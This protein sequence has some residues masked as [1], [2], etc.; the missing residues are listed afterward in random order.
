MS[1]IDNNLLPDEKIIFRTK[2]HPIVFLVPGIFLLLAIFFSTDNVLTN[3][4]NHTFSLVTN[5]IPAIHSIHRLPGLLFTLAFIVSGTQQWILYQ[6]SD[7]VVTSNRVIMREGLFI[8]RTSDMRLSTIASVSTDQGLLAQMLNYG[9]ISLNGF[10]GLSED[11][12]QIAKP[13]EF[14]KYAHIQLGK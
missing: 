5:Q 9:N 10:G 14:Q 3:A 4:M 1:Y 6:M 2:K 12:M 7:Y 11:F 13:I 8:R